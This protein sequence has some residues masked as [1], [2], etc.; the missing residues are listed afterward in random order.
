MRKAGIASYAR[1]VRVAIAVVVAACGSAP[2]HVSNAPEAKAL[3]CAMRGEAS[4][5]GATLFQAG[6]AERVRGSEI[7]YLVMHAPVGVELS[8]V[9]YRTRYYEVASVAVRAPSRGPALVVTGWMLLSALERTPLVPTTGVDCF[10]S[11]PDVDP[12]KRPT[13]VCNDDCVRD[14]FDAPV[15][16]ERRRIPNERVVYAR[17][18]DHAAKIGRV[19]AGAEVAVLAETASWLRIASSGEELVGASSLGDLTDGDD[20]WIAK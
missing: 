15:V 19:E 10:A 18:S 8:E 1:G 12:R 6:D 14:S 7:A 16:K 11:A 3:T 17:P 2:A 4:L 5:D 13:P 20:L 9:R